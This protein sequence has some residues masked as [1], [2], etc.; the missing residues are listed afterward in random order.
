MSAKIDRLRLNEG[1]CILVK[2]GESTEVSVRVWV[3]NGKLHI[4][5][6][7]NML[8]GAFVIEEV[9]ISEVK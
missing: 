1:D 4:S 9:D 8:G 7:F 3:E 2:N 6:P 5:G